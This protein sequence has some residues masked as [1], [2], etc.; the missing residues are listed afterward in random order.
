[1]KPPP[2]PPR[3]VVRQFAAWFNADELA[4]LSASEREARAHSSGLELARELGPRAGEA[5]ALLRAMLDTPSHPL[6]GEI[7]QYSLYGWNSDDDTL[8]CFRSLATV[9]ADAIDRR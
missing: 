1:M 5:A 6:F 2:T 4:G 9:M 8:A 7:E 3:A